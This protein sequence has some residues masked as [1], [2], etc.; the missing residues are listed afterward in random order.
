[1]NSRAAQTRSS[2]HSPSGIGRL[3]RGLAGTTLLVAWGDIQKNDL[4]ASFAD[5]VRACG[6]GLFLCSKSQLL[7][8]YLLS[9]M[10]E[11]TGAIV[12]GVRALRRV[13]VGYF[14]DLYALQVS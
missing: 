14:E 10:V 5:S 11:L 3:E 9:G 4:R 7:A 12:Y 13:G 8:Q 1:M 2:E 6:K